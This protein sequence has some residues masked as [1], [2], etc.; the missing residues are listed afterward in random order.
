MKKIILIVSCFVTFCFY[1]F[2]Q[3]ADNGSSQNSSDGK[4]VINNYNNYNTYNNYYYGSE[5]QKELLPTPKQESKME[6]SPKLDTLEKKSTVRDSLYDFISI[7]YNFSPNLF[8][9]GVNELAKYYNRNNGYQNY[10]YKNEKDYAM[11]FSFD[12]RMSKR[13]ALS[14]DIGYMNMDVGIGNYYLKVKAMPWAVGIKI[15]PG[16]KGLSGF[17]LYPKIGGLNTTFNGT[18]MNNAI[19]YNGDKNIKQHG[20]YA[21]MELGWR[22]KLFPKSS[23]YWP[24]R[25]AIDISLFDI[26]Y[27]FTPWNSKIMASIEENTPS[28]LPKNMAWLNRMKLDIFPRIGFSI[29]F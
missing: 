4:T 9:V 16:G 18:Y 3:E 27:Y 12:I 22:I 11:A 7:G 29:I 24:I 26:G 28:A 23:A 10:Q 2:A 8:I 1:A 13:L 25:I 6:E 15:F 19:T 14:G 21:S 5:G 20:M 17:F